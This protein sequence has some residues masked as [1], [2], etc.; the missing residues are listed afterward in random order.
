MRAG[1][2]KRRRKSVATIRTMKT[3]DRRVNMAAVLLPPIV[4]AVAIALGWNRYVGAADLAIF[5]GM[6]LLT[7]F[8]ITLGFHRLLTHR[9]FATSRPLQYAFAIA[10]SMAVQGPVISW[11]ADHRK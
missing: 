2:V 9:A 10:G 6:Y 11:V 8:G 4:I 7:G 1:R 5:A 3:F